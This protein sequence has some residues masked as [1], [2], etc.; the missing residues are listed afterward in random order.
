MDAVYLLCGGEGPVI[1]PD[2]DVFNRTV[3]PSVIKH[4][5]ATDHLEKSQN[6]TGGDILSI[7]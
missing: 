7:F 4:F 3:L 5:R 6:I 2:A 1:P